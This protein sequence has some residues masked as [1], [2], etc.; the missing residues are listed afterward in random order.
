MLGLHTFLSL[1]FNDVMYNKLSGGVQVDISLI[2]S[3]F[4]V[5]DLKKNSKEFDSVSIIQRSLIY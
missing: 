3:K 1:D 5:P 4:T 2:I